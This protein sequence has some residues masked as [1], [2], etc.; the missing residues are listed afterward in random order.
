MTKF[1]MNSWMHVSNFGNRP[2]SLHHLGLTSQASSFTRCIPGASDKGTF[3]E[4]APV[5]RALWN[6]WPCRVLAVEPGQLFPNPKSKMETPKMKPTHLRRLLGHCIASLPSC[7]AVNCRSFEVLI[8]ELIVNP[9]TCC[10]PDWTDA[11]RWEPWLD[12]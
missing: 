12:R 4:I 11:Y 2:L 6:I 8:S 3:F 7:I 10:E 1:N 5:P 9:E